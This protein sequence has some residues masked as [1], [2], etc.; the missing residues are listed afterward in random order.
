LLATGCLLQ[1]LC[2]CGAGFITDS[3]KTSIDERITISSVMN[4][5]TRELLFPARAGAGECDFS[6]FSF[7][8]A[9]PHAVYERWN[10]PGCAEW[11]APPEI[12]VCSPRERATGLLYFMRKRPLVK[13]KSVSE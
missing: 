8:L 3:K 13:I 5:C 4:F 6:L 7:S 9:A 12:L 2:F 11:R 1:I 10:Q